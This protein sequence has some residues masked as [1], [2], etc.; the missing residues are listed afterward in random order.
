MEI[1]FGSGKIKK[2]ENTIHH[3]QPLFESASIKLSF[4]NF[5]S[6]NSGHQ[7]DIS[8]TFLK[9]PYDSNAMLEV[10]LCLFEIHDHGL[11]SS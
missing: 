1:L 2:L 3:I 8:L 7:C 6:M 11:N 4:N 9:I 10:G 5:L